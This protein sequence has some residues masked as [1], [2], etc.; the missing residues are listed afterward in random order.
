MVAC[1]EYIKTRKQTLATAMPAKGEKGCQ[2][3]DR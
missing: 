3:A 1:K 2:E